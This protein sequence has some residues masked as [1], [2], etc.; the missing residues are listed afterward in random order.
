MLASDL[1]DALHAT[2]YDLL[3][4]EGYRVC[5]PRDPAGGLALLRA[6]DCGAV[7][8]VPLPPASLISQHSWLAALAAAQSNEPLIEQRLRSRCALIGLAFGPAADENA[9]ASVPPLWDAL[10]TRW[11]A[12]LSAP[13]DLESLISALTAAS[14]RLQSAA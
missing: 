13:F 9:F 6:G 3:I 11:R 1:D 4:D 10:M 14:Q 2:L 7:V 8:I 5:A 12:T